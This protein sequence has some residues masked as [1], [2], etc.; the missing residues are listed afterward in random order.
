MVV[1]KLEEREIQALIRKL[2]SFVRHADLPDQRSIL[3]A[4]LKETVVKDRK[5]VKWLYE[6][7][8]KFVEEEFK[9]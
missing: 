8:R 3:W 7:L 6:E 5:G 2:R 1:M 4:L 9:R